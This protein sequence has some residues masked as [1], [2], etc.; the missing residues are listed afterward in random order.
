MSPGK[1]RLL[2]RAG[3]AGGA[4]A[5]AFA[6]IASVGGAVSP[7]GT[8]AVAAEYPKKVTICHRTKSKKHPFVTITV[9]K[10]AVPAH[11]KHGDTVGPCSTALFTLCQKA[12][13]KD[14]KT[15]K[16]KGAKNALK[17]LRR[18]AKLG[19]CKAQHQQGTKGKKGK[20]HQS[21]TNHGKSGE[22]GKSGDHGKPAETPGKG[23]GKGKKP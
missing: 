10:N 4:A 17:Q 18:G 22:K 7:S 11:L 6:A 15:V 5:I 21:A 8:P 20:K 23:G 3:I 19:K 1:A 16:V 12:K 9:S 13:G 14:L 2:F